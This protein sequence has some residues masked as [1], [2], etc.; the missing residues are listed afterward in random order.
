MAQRKRSDPTEDRWNEAMSVER[1]SQAHDIVGR[2]MPRPDAAS[3][4]WMDF[5]RRSV[6]V[7]ERVAEVDRGHHHEALYWAGRE[8]V[9]AELLAS[10]DR[11]DE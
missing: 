4:V 6:R 2:L 7:Y 8:R 1:L 9:K 5:Y 10:S 3:E 11:N